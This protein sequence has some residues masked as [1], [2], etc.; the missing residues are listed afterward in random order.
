MSVT[1]YPKA[2]FVPASVDNVGGALQPNAV[3]LFVVHVA[4]GTNQS[5]IDA[6]FRNPAAKVSAHFSISRLGVV[7]QHVPLDRIAWAERDYNDVAIS[8]EHLG[9]S[10]Q[11]LTRR[12]LNASMRLLAWLHDQFPRVTL[13]RTA[14]GDGYGVI[15][16]GELGIPGGDH[17]NCPGTPI[18][19][20]VA[21]RLERRQW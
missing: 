9:Y 17:P 3:R 1:I 13:R 16:H 15:G 20:Q 14:R 6:W 18:L 10:G 7:H 21:V 12:Q 2:K 19:D 8:I 5:G 11:K 4:Q